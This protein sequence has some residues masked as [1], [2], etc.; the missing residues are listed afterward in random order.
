[1][2]RESCITFPSSISS[3]EN[4]LRNKKSEPLVSTALTFKRR[5]DFLS[6]I[7]ILTFAGFVRLL[8]NLRYEQRLYDISITYLAHGASPSKIVEGPVVDFVGLAFTGVVWSCVVTI[9]NSVISSVLEIEQSCAVSGFFPS[10]AISIGPASA[11]VYA[12]CFVSSG[13]IK[14]ADVV[15]A[16]MLHLTAW[17]LISAFEH[18]NYVMEGTEASGL[19][20]TPYT[21]EGKAVVRDTSYRW[22][23]MLFAIF[24]TLVSVMSAW[25]GVRSISSPPASAFAGLILGSLISASPILYG[26]GY[27]ASTEKRTRIMLCS[28][29]S[30]AH[31]VLMLV[32]IVVCGIA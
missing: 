24:L 25:S 21:R 3:T 19:G 6:C 23:P 5:S 14:G 31:Q 7:M 27:T 4:N 1:M 2:S 11:A 12:L 16:F 29:H 13:G 18:G 8:T 15:S 30:V 28:A 9:F 20:G 32:G 22:I 17:L 10:R 26:L